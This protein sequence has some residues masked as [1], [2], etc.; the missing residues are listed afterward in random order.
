MAVR[1]ICK[2]FFRKGE[3]IKKE[4]V[5]LERWGVVT[6]LELCIKDLFLFK[7]FSFTLKQQEDDTVITEFVEFTNKQK[8]HMRIIHLYEL[9]SSIVDKGIVS[10]R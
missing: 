3:I 1:E 9:L 6:H 7:Y 5:P 2:F 10:S 8:R 4:G